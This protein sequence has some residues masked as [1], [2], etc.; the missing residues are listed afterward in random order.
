M[1]RSEFHLKM[2]NTADWIKDFV[3]DSDNDY[4]VDE[5]FRYHS[6]NSAKRENLYRLF[7]GY[8][9]DPENAGDNHDGSHRNHSFI[10]SF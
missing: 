6:V 5:F 3:E 1:S 4:E 10:R 7:Y 9:P 2:P 8:M